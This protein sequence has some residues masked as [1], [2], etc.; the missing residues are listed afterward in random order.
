MNIHQRTTFAED[1]ANNQIDRTAIL[2]T[3]INFFPQT[4]L[5]LS[6]SFMN[7]ETTGGRRV[8]VWAQP[9]EYPPTMAEQVTTTN[10]YS[11]CQSQSST[12]SPQSSTSL[13]ND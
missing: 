3:P 12:L 9:H 5:S 8:C 13:W 10:K 11:I 2:W 4:F 6:N 7:S 1:D